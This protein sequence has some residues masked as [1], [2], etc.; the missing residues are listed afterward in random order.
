MNKL[1]QSVMP[2]WVSHAISSM[3]EAVSNQKLG[4]AKVSTN[5]EKVVGRS[6]RDITLFLPHLG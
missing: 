1:V 3:Y 6:A 2:E 5:F 4:Y